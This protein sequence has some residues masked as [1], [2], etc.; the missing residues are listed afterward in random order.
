[1]IHRAEALLARRWVGALIVGA[2]AFALYLRT[3]ARSA[4]FGDG[5]ELATA[6]YHLGVPH[7]TGY[8]LWTL[9][10]HLFIRALPFGEVIF[11][12]TLL[13]VTASAAAVAVV[14]VLGVLL[15]RR[16][17]IAAFVA[18]LFAVS[19]SFWSQAIITEVYA[20]NSLIMFSTIACLGYW[21]R[22]GSRRLLYAAALL[23]GLGTAHHLMSIMWW[24]AYALL[25]LTS[26]RRSEIRRTWKR[27]LPLMVLP[28]ALYVYLPLAAR[29]DP[30]LSWGDTTTLRNVILHVTGA[31]YRHY[32]GHSSPAS[33]WN[34]IYQYGGWPEDHKCDGHLL[35]QFSL[36]I[37]WL[38][39]V[40]LWSWWRRN[41]RW[42]GIS[43]T[44][45]LVLLAWAFNYN[46]SDPEGYYI[47]T[48]LMVALWI[49]A[50]LREMEFRLARSM[51]RFLTGARERKR[52]RAMLQAGLLCLPILVLIPN[53][54]TND[55]SHRAEI[56]ELGRAALRQ[57]PPNAVVITSGDD[58]GF[59]FMYVQNVEGLRPDVVVFLEPFLVDPNYR[60]VLRET[61]RGV[62]IVEPV[63]P[64]GEPVKLYRMLARLRRLVLDNYKERPVFVVGP[65]LDRIEKS[66]LTKKQLPRMKRLMAKVPMARFDPESEP[67][68]PSPEIYRPGERQP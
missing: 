56:R 26:P 41:R 38:A 42:F 34:R 52:I 40:G 49:G 58:W 64:E 33:L 61:R 18:L 24:P 17:W 50:G 43:L 19:D 16:R 10:G 55:W 12:T 1:M 66:R 65:L 37:L 46:I 6:A 30:P 39:P 47:P 13:S 36:A 14:Y 4:V 63:Y 5:P 48:H 2:L 62:R 21:D 20:L 60:L 32:M 53:W 54:R 8:P 67:E 25:V 57:L 3:A 28:V 59:A 15:F 45:Y 31:Q 29:R 22:T 27:W 9:L 51:R 7:P 44:A 11:R 23:M 68:V 35:T